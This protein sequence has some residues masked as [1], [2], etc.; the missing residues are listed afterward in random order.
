LGTKFT[1]FVEIRH[2]QNA[3]GEV[4]GMAERNRHPQKKKLP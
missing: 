2:R 3:G 1:T 4:T